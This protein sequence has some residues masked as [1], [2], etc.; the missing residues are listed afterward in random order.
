MQELSYYIVNRLPKPYDL[1]INVPPGSTK[2][3]I[4]TIMFPVWLCSNT[5]QKCLACDNTTFSR[6]N[7]C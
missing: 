5:I 7:I 1:I 2:S 6:F 3:T 4:T